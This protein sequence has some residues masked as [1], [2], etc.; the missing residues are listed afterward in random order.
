MGLLTICPPRLPCLRLTDLGPAKEAAGRLSDSGPGGP[1]PGNLALGKPNPQLPGGR[2][3]VRG[4]Q[5]DAL[6]RG[7]EKAEDEPVNRGDRHPND[8]TDDSADQSADHEERDAGKGQQDEDRA[9]GDVSTRRLAPSLPEKRAAPLDSGPRTDLLEDQ[10]RDDE[11]RHDA[12]GGPREPGDD[13][14]DEPEPLC[15]RPQD[16]SDRRAH[17]GPAR[18]PIPVL[19][20]NPEAVR[21]R[22]VSTVQADHGGAHHRRVEINR[23]EEREEVDEREADVERPATPRTRRGRGEEENRHEEC[24]PRDAGQKERDERED[25]EA[26]L[27]PEDPEADLREP[28]SDP[29]AF[30]E[31]ELAGLRREWSTHV[32]AGDRWR[33][34][35]HRD[36]AT[37]P[38]GA[39]SIHRRNAAAEDPPRG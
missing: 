1:A 10:D 19:P 6:C 39:R 9:E 29:H 25:D 22:R 38:D 27:L 5:E 15:E 30:E 24:E 23:D 21:D 26:L 12:P 36:R 20:R 34:R 11:I 33:R 31:S 28:L 35:P 7:P 13:P 2:V 18:D 8:E 4:G 16:K 37:H 14:P 17:E 3:P 32:R